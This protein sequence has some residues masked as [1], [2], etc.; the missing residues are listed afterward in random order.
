M[1]TIVSILLFFT[2]FQCF[3]TIQI[4]DL[5]CYDGINYE[6]KEEYLEVYFEKYPE[7]RPKNGIISSNLW[8]GYV[9]FF[10]VENNKVYLTDLKI[11]VRVENSKEFYETK[12]ISVFTEFTADK[13]KI[14]IDWINDLAILPIGEV[15]DYE[16]GFGISFSNYELIEISNGNVIFSKKFDLD[17]YKSLLKKCHVFLKREDLSLLKEK[18]KN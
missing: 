11:K 13:D 4:K 5:I 7:K 16:T 17:F 12:F 14:L 10:T 8:R 15:I 9:A 1:K 6:L 3:S 18:L 2:Y